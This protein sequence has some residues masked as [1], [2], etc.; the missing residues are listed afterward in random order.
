MTSSELSR[1]GGTALWRQIAQG[2]EETIVGGGLQPGERLPTEQQLASRYGVN[3]HTVRQ[4]LAALA[5][6]GLVRI[7]QGRGSFVQESVIDYRV[8]KRTR[9]SENIAQQKREPRGRLLRA[10]ELQADDAVARALEIRKGGAVILLETIGEAD[11]RPVSVASHY[12]PKARFPE[13][14]TAYEETGSISQALARYGIADYTRKVTRV[15]ARLP[16]A[17]DARLLQ[18]PGNRP[19]LLTEGINVD[20][21]GHPV[22][23]SVARF[24]SDRVQ[25]VFEPGC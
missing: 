7:E 16:R 9:F 6:H 20:A 19:I 14:K 18:Q 12:F 13:L 5:D 17:A 22:E 8:R 1:C 23:Y 10:V 21:A 11:D 4:A 3:R 15:T 2:L 25:I 24:A